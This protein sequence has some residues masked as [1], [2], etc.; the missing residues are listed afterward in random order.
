MA[1]IPVVGVP[2]YLPVQLRVLL[3]L[4]PVEADAEPWSV[5]DAYVPF[6]VLE[7]ATLDHVVREV[8]VVGVGREGEVR[9]HGTEVEHGS[10]LNAQFTRGVNGHAQ[11]E[12][13]AHRSGLD[14]GPEAAPEGRVEQNDVRSGV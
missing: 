4:H 6:P 10:Q 12:R 1:R 13:L 5:R 3:Q 9:H 2:S 11:L 7:L 14:A 8:M